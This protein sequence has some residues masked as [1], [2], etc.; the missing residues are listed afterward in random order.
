MRHDQG[1]TLRE[2][3]EKMGI[4]RPAVSKMERKADMSIGR[5]AEFVEALGRPMAHPGLV[6]GRAAPVS[7]ASAFLEPPNEDACSKSSRSKDEAHGYV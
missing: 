1:L 7:R 5:F 3:A 2:V 4:K 6:R